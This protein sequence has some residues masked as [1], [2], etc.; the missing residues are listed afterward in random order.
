V[1]PG[2]TDQPKDLEAVVRAAAEAGAR[3][4]Y[5][6]PLFL[7]P[8]SEKVFMP[9]LQE[10]FPHLVENYRKRYGEKAFVSSAY[11]KRIAELMR[12]LRNKYGMSDRRVEPY[13]HHAPAAAEAGQL[14]LF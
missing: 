4:V 14:S 2:I 7:K 5:S 8:C 6:N 12:S 9:F 13:E 11:S 10:K 3:G 1:L